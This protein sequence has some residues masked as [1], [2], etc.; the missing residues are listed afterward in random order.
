MNNERELFFKLMKRTAKPVLPWIM[1]FFNEKTAEK[2]LGYENVPRDCIPGL[3]Y[4]AGGS[5][6]DDWEKKVNYSHACGNFAAGVGWGTC[7]Y[8]GHGGPGEFRERL[9]ETGENLRRSEFETGT[10][11][12]VRYNPHFYHHYDFPAKGPGDLA[13]LRL[14]DPN[15]PSRYEGI[16]EETAF[17]RGKGCIV[18]GNVNG[19]FSGL[20]YFLYPYDMLLADLLLEP[21]FIMEMLNKVGEFNLAAAENLLKC[22]VD[23]ITFCDD[24][25]SGTSMLI[26]PGLYRR[27]FFP[28]H[29]KLADLCHSYGA[30]LHMHSHGNI[31]KI[32]DDI[33]ESGVDILN[34]CDPNDGMDLPLLKRKYGDRIIFAGGISKFFF[35]WNFARQKDYIYNLVKE[36][37]GGFILMD[38]G[39]IPEY[40][41]PEGFSRIREL[42]EEIKTAY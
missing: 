36:A 26:S 33:Y 27:F 21:E 15:D 10:K 16:A 14:P 6:K 7:I 31:N 22:G 34:P 41:T 2:L 12:E 24:L 38:S 30:Y 8:F 9:I 39:G 11:K 25:G 13:N 29:K 23:M 20:H 35:D 18:Y 37:G 32:M 28:W 17:Y 19:F 40:V 42:F 5:D 4:N 1:S 3:S